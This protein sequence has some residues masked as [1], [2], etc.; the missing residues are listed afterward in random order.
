MSVPL[1]PRRRAKRRHPKTGQPRVLL[2]ARWVPAE[3]RWHVSVEW[4]RDDL[5]Q[6]PDA[7][8][9]WS[10][11]MSVLA[12]VTRLAETLDALVMRTRPPVG[13]DSLDLRSPPHDP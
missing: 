11:G 2:D 9:V 6:E 10:S 8:E 1:P 4:Y 7:I 12:I 13:G 5:A 3:G